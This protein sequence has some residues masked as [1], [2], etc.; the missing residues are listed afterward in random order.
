MWTEFE[1]PILI[2][3][4]N[5]ES[6]EDIL[7][8]GVLTV[9]DHFQGSVTV[10]G[11]KTEAINLMFLFDRRKR[12]E[13]RANFMGIAKVFLDENHQGIAAEHYQPGG[14]NEDG[15]G[16]EFDH[17]HEISDFI[18]TM[19]ALSFFHC[20]NVELKTKAPNIR[21]ANKFIKKYH[22]APAVWNVIHVHR[23]TKKY[24]E[25]GPGNKRGALIGASMIRGHFKKYTSD[26]PLLG[27][28]VGMY[29][30]QSHVRGSGVPTAHDYKV[31]EPKGKHRKECVIQ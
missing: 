26:A 15:A 13:T 4:D 3:H 30:W 7:E 24:L 14:S 10:G 23:L 5:D 6:T 2:R 29:F 12:S 21:K 25:K 31:H 9:E 1:Q 28:H 18:P 19:S 22:T 16:V 17:D 8:V 20:K 27:K 11:V